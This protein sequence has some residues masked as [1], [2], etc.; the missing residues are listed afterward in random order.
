[1]EPK[2]LTPAER[3][4]KSPGFSLLLISCLPVPPISETGGK[5]SYRSYSFLKPP[6]VHSLVS[7]HS[8]AHANFWQHLLIRCP[9]NSKSDMRASVKR[10]ALLLST[11]HQ[12]QL[13]A[14]CLGTE[15]CLRDSLQGSDLLNSRSYT[16]SW[17]H[18]V[19]LHYEDKHKRAVSVL[20]IV[21]VYN[22]TI[23]TKI[24]SACSY[25]Q[26]P[27]GKDFNNTTKYEH[28]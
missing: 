2:W 23:R 18:Q 14:G 24:E 19:K 16:K 13:V 8:R 7:L 27:L 22:Q 21:R 1:M 5:H 10:H 25:W 17:A 4:E 15:S 11:L 6:L 3:E 20:L 12:D 28:N 9:N 26:Q